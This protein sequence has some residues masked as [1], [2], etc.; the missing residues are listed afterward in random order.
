M[1]SI[2][3]NIW[4]LVVD[5]NVYEHKFYCT[6]LMD[7]KYQR[8]GSI[9]QTLMILYYI[10]KY[11]IVLYHCLH[12]ACTAKLLRIE[13]MEL[14]NLFKDKEMDYITIEHNREEEK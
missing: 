10:W 2:Y 6:S 4:A 12:V 1:K 8:Q 7:N 13:N 5:L 9:Y 3:I 14:L 11:D